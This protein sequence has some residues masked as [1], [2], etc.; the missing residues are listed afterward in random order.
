MMISTLVVTKPK[1]S[2]MAPSIKVTYFNIR[3]LAETIRLLLKY[4]EIEF[5]DVRIERE[6]WPALKANAPFGQMPLYEEDGK[7]AWQSIAICR[8]L[9]KKVNLR[10][11]NDWE[12]AEI[13]AIA[14]TITDFRL[15]VAAIMQEKDETKKEQLKQTLTTETAP[16]Y[17]QRFDKIVEENGGYFVNK[18]LTW[19]DFYFFALSHIATFLLGP[20]GL[21]TYKNLL[22][23]MDNV[24]SIPTIKAW[25]EERP[26]TEF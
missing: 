4:G 5:E 23:V 18:K 20:D 16:Y 13:D 3:G 24:Q 6:E 17:L 1:I 19:V 12:D 7:V 21:S 8:Y 14:D 9:A 2:I 22:T 25:I 10:G 15:K 11:A 26:K